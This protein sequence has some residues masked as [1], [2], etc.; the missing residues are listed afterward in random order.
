MS[1][2]DSS[3]FKP[4]PNFR[5]RRK[6]ALVRVQLY[7]ARNELQDVMV[8]NISSTGIRATARMT[9]PEK[10]EVI[11]VHL[12]D[13]TQLWGIVRWVDGKEFGVEFDV[14]SPLADFGQGGSREPP[15]PRFITSG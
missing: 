1:F 15:M 12:P 13:S 7:N 2:V 9:P 5:A 6:R 10:D 3:A 8:I 14:T 4:T 11:T